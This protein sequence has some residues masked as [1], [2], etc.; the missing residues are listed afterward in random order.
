LPALGLCRNYS[1]DGAEGDHRKFDV[2][3]ELEE[4]MDKKIVFSFSEEF[5]H[6]WVKNNDF[7]YWFFSLLLF[8]V[9]PTLLLCAY[10]IWSPINAPIVAKAMCIKEGFLP[11]SDL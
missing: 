8:F 7:V 11:S 10:S 2:L 6:S 4:A 9:I 1:S 5:G 3:L